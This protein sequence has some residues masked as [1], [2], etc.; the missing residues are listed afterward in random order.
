MKTFPELVIFDCD[1]VL[2]DSEA[3]AARIVSQTLADYD[4]ELNP[5]DVANQ[6]AGY[7]DDAIRDHFNKVSDTKLPED[8]AQI[9]ERGTIDQ[10][11]GALETLP[12]IKETLS[13]LEHPFC[14]ASNSRTDRLDSALDK[15]GLGR[16]FPKER[17]F[18][19]SMVEHPK[20]APDLHLMACEMMKVKPEQALIIEDTVT[21]VTGGKN[22][23]IAVLGFV[24]AEH[25]VDKNVQGRKLMEAGAYAVF[26]DM[27][28]LSMMLKDYAA[29]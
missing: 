2:V 18:S 15:T 13:I 24:G 16:F 27:R 10:M 20:P 29:A 28:Q 12:Y 23:G 1:G 26:D 19:S 21:G 9:V 3:L 8:F 22:A 5:Q 11:A 6:F 4:I 25:I 17:R 7:T 14:V